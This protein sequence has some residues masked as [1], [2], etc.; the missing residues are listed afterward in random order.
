VGS[1]VTTH[2]PTRKGTTWRAPTENDV[3]AVATLNRRIHTVEPLDYVAGA[4]YIRWILD[5]GTIDPET[6]LRVAV[7]GSGDVLAFG[8]SWPHLTDVGARCFLWAEVDPKAHELQDGLIAWVVARGKEQLAGRAGGSTGMLRFAMETDRR[9]A[10]EAIEAAG[11][12]DFRSFAT[13]ER[14]LVDPPMAPPVPEGVRVTRWSPEYDA[15]T[16]D[17]YNQAFA[18]HWGSLPRTQEMWRD[19]VTGSRQFRPDLSYLAVADDRVVAFCIC[20]VDEDHNES[21]GESEVYIELVGTAREHRGHGLASHLIVRTLE[22]AATAGLDVATLTVD[23]MSHTNATEVYRRL[24]FTVRSR[25][26]DYYL[27]VASSE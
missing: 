23:E 25:T 26:A 10:R 3:D 11:F 8:G 12:F 4:D 2:L 14:P 18:D 1:A 6:D 27:E 24:G 20:E 17:A 15:S 21:S 7:D 5:Q 13:M 22:D 9:R 19:I 16:C